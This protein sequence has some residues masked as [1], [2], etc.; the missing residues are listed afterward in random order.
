[1]FIRRKLTLRVAH[2]V[3]HIY[4]YSS[5]S[6]MRTPIDQNPGLFPEPELS[7]PY[8]DHKM[9]KS[10]YKLLPKHDVHCEA[11]LLDE[12]IESE[13]TAT[14]EINFQRFFP[15]IKNIIFIIYVAVSLPILV[16]TVWNHRAHIYSPVNPLIK[17]ERQPLHEEHEDLVHKGYVGN[18]EDTEENWRRLLEPMNFKATEDELLKSNIKIDDRIVRVSGGGYVGV[19]SVYHELHCLEALRR[20][21]LRSYYYANMTAAGMDHDDRVIGHLTHCIEYIRRTIMCHADVSVYAATWIADSHEKPNKDLISNGERECVNWDA[22][23]KWSR[24]RALKKKVYKVKPGPFEKNLH[25]DE[26]DLS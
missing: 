25:P 15:S 7:P 13:E 26:G 12:K 11:P 16:S 18:P 21:T 1:M 4:W 9:E 17:Y 5:L 19:L 22:I 2:N 20:S 6:W 10:W 24:E 23:D 3:H 14:P 8:S